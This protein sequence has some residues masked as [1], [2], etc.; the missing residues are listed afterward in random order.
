MTACTYFDNAAT[1]FPKPQA[2]LDAVVEYMSRIGGNP[3]RSGHSLSV[4]AGEIIFSARQSV[5]D[6]LGIANPMRVIFCFNA[7]DALNL[8]IQGVVQTGDHV[9]TTAMEHNSTIR[10]LKALEKEGCIRLSVIDCSPHGRIDI[11]RF[12]GSI[13]P[14]TKLAVVN[15]AS[16]VTGTVQP[17]KE[18]GA[19]CR[20]KGVVLLADCAQSLGVVPI[21]MNAD[22]I[23]LLAF[24]GHKNL[25]GPAGTGGLVIAESFDHKRLKPLRYGG[26]GSA[27]ERIFQPEFLPDCFESGTL[28][29]AGINGLHTGILH[30]TSKDLGIET[31]SERKSALTAYFLSRARQE[32]ETFHSYVPDKLIQTGVVSFNLDGIDPSETAR[33][34]SDE[35][36]IFCRTGLHCAP[37]AHQTIGTFPAGTVRFSFGIFNTTHEIDRAVSALKTIHKEGIVK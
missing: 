29:C 5:A 13:T 3:G 9:M 32:I 21:D 37:L 30:I 19:L 23:D 24:A 11:D 18:I 16:N 1:S 14:K 33:I 27:S 35:Y 4:K 34:L 15:H 36:N 2:V 26:T 31:I 7:T 28:N 17:L 6:L 8:A 25:Y 12:A 22:H 10:P 20:Q